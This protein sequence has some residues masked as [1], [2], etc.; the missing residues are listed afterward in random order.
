MVI[1]RPLGLYSSYLRFRKQHA[2]SIEGTSSDKDKSATMLAPSLA[3]GA[4]RQGHPAI[5]AYIIEAA[6]FIES[7]VAPDRFS[8]SR[9]PDLNRKIDIKPNAEALKR[10]GSASRN[11]FLI[12]PSQKVADP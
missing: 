8:D 6:D 7:L 11:S 4:L 2:L 5:R 9:S 3:A 12:P 1:L 10:S